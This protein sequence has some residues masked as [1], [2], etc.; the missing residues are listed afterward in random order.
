MST[1]PFHSKAIQIKNRPENQVG[2]LLHLYDFIGKLL[3][4]LRIMCHQ[5]HSAAAQIFKHTRRHT[6]SQSRVQSL[7]RFVQKHQRRRC[8]Q[9]SGQSDRRFMPPLSC[10]TGKSALSVS[11]TSSSRRSTSA[12]CRTKRIFSRAVRPGSNRFSWNRKAHVPVPVTPL[13]SISSPAQIRRQVVFPSPE[14]P[15]SAVTRPA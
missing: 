14:G 8:S 11:S 6:V 3:G 1:T 15:N 7:E 13:S 12:S 10:S 9:H 2:F 4:L 5:H